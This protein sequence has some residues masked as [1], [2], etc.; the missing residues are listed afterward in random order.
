MS[1]WK[2]ERGV[3]MSATPVMAGRVKRF[4]V[5]T[6]LCMLIDGISGADQG[7]VIFLRHFSI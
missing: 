2:L 5:L 7:S 1:P 4:Y 6:N 3:T